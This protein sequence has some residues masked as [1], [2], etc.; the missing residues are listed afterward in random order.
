MRAREAAVRILQNIEKDNEFASLAIKKYLPVYLN[1][2][3]E[4]AL[5]TELIYGVLR[6]KKRLDF[7]RD[8]YL[9][10]KA[11]KLEDEIIS[12]IRVSIYQILFCHKIPDS[13]A[14]N[15]AVKLTRKFKKYGASAFV[16]GILRTISK[17]KEDISYPEEDVKRLGVITSFPMRILDIWISD[18]GFQKAKEI[19]EQSNIPKPISYR[20]NKLKAPSD[21]E[22]PEDIGA[23]ENEQIFRDGF[24]TVQDKG[25]QMAVE[26]L[27]PK[28]DSLVLDLCAAPG[29]KTCY[30]SEFMENTGK[31]VACDV[32]EHRLALIENTASRLGAKNI[33]VTQNDGSVFKEEWAN[34]FDYV[35]ADVPCSGLGVISSKPDI[36]WRKQNLEDLC[37]LQLEI[38]IN[39]MQY[40]KTGGT[41]LY[42]TCTIHKA[43]NQDII[44]KALEKF[45]NFE[46]EEQKQLFP[47]SSNDGFFICKLKRCK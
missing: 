20:I 15:E 14:C 3:K 7:V 10:F 22:I 40:V 32:Y 36:K 8:C 41:L 47:C 19:A 24:V 45:D 17:N 12:I 35:L 26:T 25:S 34:K 11:T 33:E 18:Y 46:I 39:A 21:F 38:L 43:E 6:Y 23:P 27:C 4:K 13:A 2:A 28:K 31:I 42:S 44:N 37:K 16:N 29:G 9:K 5:A 1:D 30:I